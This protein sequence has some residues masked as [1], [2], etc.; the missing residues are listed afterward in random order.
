MPWEQLDLTLF[1]SVQTVVAFRLPCP[2]EALS[3]L[4]CSCLQGGVGNTNGLFSINF[5]F[6]PRNMPDHLP[7]GDGSPSDHRGR[8]AHPAVIVK[9]K[10]R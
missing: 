9:N 10:K 7:P 3:F 4:V 6:N 5:Y 1:V 2:F 8:R